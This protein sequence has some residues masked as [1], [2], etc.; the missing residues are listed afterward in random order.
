[1]ECKSTSENVQSIKK[2]EVCS[3][4]FA[5]V[6]SLQRHR[7]CMKACKRNICADNSMCKKV[8]LDKVFIKTNC[9]ELN[10]SESAHNISTNKYVSDHAMNKHLLTFE[11][12]NDKKLKNVVNFINNKLIIMK[13]II[14]GLVAEYSCI[15]VNFVI[16][17]NF[18]NSI[19]ET[20]ERNFKIKSESFYFNTNI[21]DFIN[22]ATSKI[23]NE[24]SEC[25]LK[26]S[27]WSLY[28]INK[29]HL[30][31][32]K[33]TP[34]SGKCHISLPSFIINKHCVVNPLNIDNR[35]FLW[36]LLAKFITGRY[37]VIKLYMEQIRRYDL[38]I[39]TFPM[40][41]D[42]I[43]KFELKNNVSVNLYSI[44][45]KKKLIYPIRVSKFEKDDHHDLLFF[46][47]MSGNGHYACIKN[48]EK[49]VRSQITNNH[50]KIFLCKNCFSHFRCE[51]KLKNHKEYCMQ[52]DQTRIVMPRI[53]NG[54]K[55]QLYF[56]KYEHT[57][58]INFNLFADF[59][60][61]LTPIHTCSPDPSKSYTV[62][63]QKHIVMSY[64]VYL[65]ST[66]DDEFLRKY[67]L[68]TA[69]YIYTGPDA[70]EN[71]MDY[72]KAIAIKISNIYKL[73]IPMNSLTN[74]QKNEYFNS[75]ICHICEKEIVRGSLDYKVRNHCHLTGAFLGSAHRYCN[76]N[77]KQPNFLNC[78][79]HALES[80]DSHII[81]QQLGKDTNR[82]DVIPSTEEKFISFSKY[83]GT[84]KVKF[85]DT[86][87]FLSSS[88]EEL[89]NNLAEDKFNDIEKFYSPAEATLLK[90]KQYFPYSYVD[91]MER[92]EEE[93]LPP[94]N[95]FYN[96][97]TEKNISIENYNHAL[98][99]WNQFKI[100]NIKNYSELYLCIDVLLLSC[101]FENFRNV[102]IKNYMIDPAW[103]YTLPSYAFDVALL[104]TQVKLDLITDYDMHLML[105]KG[106]RGGLAQCS[107]R[108]MKAE[109]KYLNP[110]HEGESKFIMYF[111]SN[112][113]YGLSMSSILPKS[114]FR[115]VDETQFNSENIL[116]LEDDAPS[117]YIFEIDIH[118]PTHLHSC[119][120]AFPL[121]PEKLVAPESNNIKL[122]ATL[123]DKFKYIIHYRHLKMALQKGMVLKKIHRALKFDQSPWLA[124][125]I[126]LNTNLRKSATN[127]F[128]KDLFKLM[129]NSFYGKTLE[130]V[131]LHMNFK[132]VSCPKR[133]QKLV[134]KPTFINTIIYNENLV[135]V[136]LLKN[137]I[138]QNKPI[139]IGFTVLELAKIHMYSFHYDVIVAKYGHNAAL[140]YMDTDSL[141][142]LLKTN[143]IYDDLNNISQ[144]FDFSNYPSSHKC[145]S[146]V[147][148]KEL[149]FF[150]DEMGGE[151]I[152]EFVGL[153][154]KMYSFKVG[155]EQTKRLKGIKKSALDNKITFND[156]LEALKTEKEILTSFY[157]IRSKK[158]VI[159]TVLQ[160][161]VSVSPFDDK[162]YILSDGIHTMAHGNVK[163]KEM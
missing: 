159:S 1:M 132:L 111:D 67:K 163:I 10:S 157:L 19:G 11:L 61:M 69:P 28:Q 90:Q 87:K 55:P 58:K 92:L 135:G 158:H 52:H 108:H 88:L 68:P 51:I 47:D 4:S 116:L 93:K 37:D 3:K 42:D 6:S 50:E 79:F 129:N 46:R 131:R 71:F 43:Y 153:R 99:V 49:L 134:A 66:F 54:E 106:I 31:I 33:Y 104:K 94:I 81:I 65:K 120:D 15:K 136:H 143:D 13:E 109:N 38:S 60:C 45:Y 154:S 137:E 150:K 152:S 123:H 63:T 122:L 142:Y 144:Y 114:H 20:T 72:I 23:L 44:N 26:K 91:S 161:K 147:N 34:L 156:Y 141:V 119:H 24:I 84:F 62:E 138:V 82:I 125:Y 148:K 89:A 105:E 118:Y 130:N 64:C 133:L 32:N 115:W 83:F 76:L 96:N 117:G 126:T 101:V 22:K 25:E 36:A 140:A 145:F 75:N 85:L 149:G 2:C 74:E 78:Y 73:N 160:N 29:M 121:L 40:K 41:I 59:E 98:N 30:N 56:K 5:T 39:I 146:E 9:E 124:P 128:D 27:G 95:C 162:R 102:S 12:E 139:Y 80:Y 113:L 7:R 57:L 70:A 103:Y 16:F 53:E 112:N 77:Y 127:S 107:L 100:K 35:C 97:L 18:I 21:I 86:Y 17:C 110:N 48:L 14:S 151:P 8:K 155:Q